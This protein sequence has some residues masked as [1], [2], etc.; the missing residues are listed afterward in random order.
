M[1]GLKDDSREVLGAKE[2]ERNGLSRSTSSMG[3]SWLMSPKHLSF[4]PATQSIH[5]LT[6]ERSRHHR[7]LIDNDD[8]VVYRLL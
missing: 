6:M 4:E 3:G 7:V 8:V 5:E 2:T 1:E